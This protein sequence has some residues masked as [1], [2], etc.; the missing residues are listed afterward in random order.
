MLFDKTSCGNKGSFKHYIRHRHKDG[1]VLPLNIENPQLTGY[2]KHFNNGGKLI[3][4]LFA[5]KELLKKYNEI[6]DKIENLF[7]K[8]FDKKL[9][10]DNKYISAKVNGTEFEHEIL[11]DNKHCNISIEPNNGSRYEYLSVILLDSILIYPASY[12][13]NKYYPQVFL[14]KCIYAKDKETTLLGK[15]IYY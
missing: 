13:S 12:C 6:W 10:Y 14:K 8:E 4:F 7:K 11:K 5:D 9:L 1:T 2:A 3:N 15:Y